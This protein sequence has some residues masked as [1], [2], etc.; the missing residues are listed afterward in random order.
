MSA[1]HDPEVEGPPEAAI[2]VALREF[3]LVYLFL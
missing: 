3:D 2:E 1:V